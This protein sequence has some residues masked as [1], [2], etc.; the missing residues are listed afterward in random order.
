MII[1]KKYNLMIEKHTNKRYLKLEKEENY[2]L[3]Q[4]LHSILLKI[5]L[6]QF[7]F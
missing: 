3:L 7:L 1:V 2:I 5:I 6:S 4:F